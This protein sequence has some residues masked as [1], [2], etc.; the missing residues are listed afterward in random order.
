MT[1]QL[2]KDVARLWVD[3][4][5]DSDGILWS[6]QQLYKEVKRLEKEK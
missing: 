1:E 5:G 6:H 2:I 4:G 3:R